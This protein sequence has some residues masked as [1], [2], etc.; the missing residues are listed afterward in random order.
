M[1]NISGYDKQQ[2]KLEDIMT[3]EDCCFNH[4][5]GLPQKDG[6]VKPLMIM[7]KQYFIV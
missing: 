1:A 6:N 3:D 2:H 4:I 7:N 5:I